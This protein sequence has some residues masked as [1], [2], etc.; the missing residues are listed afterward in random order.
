M[1]RNGRPVIGKWAVFAALS[2]LALFL[3]VSIFVK[4]SLYGP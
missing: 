3:Y 1:S 4:V 2:S